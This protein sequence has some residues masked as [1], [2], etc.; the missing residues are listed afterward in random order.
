MF[1]LT[2]TNEE[3]G[4]NRA[5]TIQREVSATSISAR[6]RKIFLKA[7]MGLA[8]YGDDSSFND[9]MATADKAMYENKKA[10]KLAARK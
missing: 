3:N 1:V 7:S 2:R 9:L 4:R 8:F 10:N 6:G 5:L